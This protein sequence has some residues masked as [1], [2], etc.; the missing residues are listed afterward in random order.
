MSKPSMSYA[1]FPTKTK[2]AGGGSRVRPPKDPRRAF[3]AGGLVDR[4]PHERRPLAPPEALL[5]VLAVF[6]DAGIEADARVVDEDAAVDLPDVNERRLSFDDCARRECQ[7]LRNAEVLREVVQGA[8]RKDAELLLGAGD[9]GGDRADGAVPA[10]RHDRGAAVGSGASGELA[11]LFAV[12]AS[13]P[14]PRTGNPERLPHA[15][16]VSAL[17]LPTTRSGRPRLAAGFT[18]TVQES[19]WKRG[20]EQIRPGKRDRSIFGAGIP[21]GSGGEGEGNLFASQ[22]STSSG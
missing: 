7:V 22:C 4:R 16:T 3:C 10:P 21:S 5:L 15:V 11:D 1:L 13:E 20:T 2:A 12:S 14:A 8:E 9:R 18:A 19:A 17:A 6:H